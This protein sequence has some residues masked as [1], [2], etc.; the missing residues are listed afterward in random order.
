MSSGISDK[1]ELDAKISKAHKILDQIGLELE[2]ENVDLK[3]IDT[4]I[5]L[6]NSAIKSFFSIDIAMPD[7]YRTLISDYLQEIQRVLEHA[8]KQKNLIEQKLGSIRRGKKVR[9]AYISNT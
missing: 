1:L 8:A 6:H 5:R 3:K 4:L 7:S 2:R 9:S